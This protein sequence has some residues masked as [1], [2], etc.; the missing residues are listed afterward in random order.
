MPVSVADL[1]IALPAADVRVANGSTPAE[2]P[3]QVETGDFHRELGRVFQVRRAD[4]EGALQLPIVKSEPSP[5]DVLPLAVPQSLVE[6]QPVPA[7]HLLAG[8]STGLV[9]QLPPSIVTLSANVPTLVEA[10][11]FESTGP[12]RLELPV[13]S[14]EPIAERQYEVTQTVPATENDVE[15]ASNDLLIARVHFGR[16]FEF[17]QLESDRGRPEL[18]GV[19]RSGLGRT[20]LESLPTATPIATVDGLVHGF[21]IEAANRSEHLLRFG[22]SHRD[23]AVD[24]EQSLFQEI[25]IGAVSAYGSEQIHAVGV[26]EPE[27]TADRSDVQIILPFGPQAARQPIEARE[28]T[29]GRPVLDD[30]L[31][32]TTEAVQLEADSG[33]HVPQELST[34]ASLNDQVQDG[35]QPATSASAPKVAEGGRVPA[36]EALGDAAQPNQPV[37]D[38]ATAQHPIVSQSNISAAADR[39]EPGPFAVNDVLAS[40]VDEVAETTITLPDGTEIPAQVDLQV[41]PT[42]RRATQTAIE[43]PVSDPAVSRPG[44]P[45]PVVRQIASASSVDSTALD[46]ETVP[47]PF[48]PAVLVQPAVGVNRSGRPAAVERPATTDARVTVAPPAATTSSSTPTS[49][50]SVAPVRFDQPT[51]ALVENASAGVGRDSIPESTDVPATFQTDAVQS[52]S[53]VAEGGQVLRREFRPTV[54]TESPILDGITAG[55]T[56]AV[57]EA[58][59]SSAID[60]PEL[61]PFTGQVASAVTRS[62]QAEALPVD[63]VRE[64]TIR[65]DPPELGALLIRMRTTD[66][67]MEVDV[68]AAD[69]VT[70]EMLSRRVPEIEQLLRM[71]K[72]GV[73]VLTVNRLPSDSGDASMMSGRNDQSSDHGLQGERNSGHDSDS[74]REHPRQQ[75]NHIHRGAQVPTA[76]RSQGGIRA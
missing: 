36:V 68:E 72:T 14:F 67:G 32:D 1:L 17:T 37:E 27:R 41:R 48:R 19:G 64:L 66:N 31:T 55:I 34:D 46:A 76:R 60:A 56:P 23:D 10:F 28:E 24:L 61:L 26:E 71:Q 8:H 12:L 11:N 57:V 4:H 25:P 33:E 22:A 15:R 35:D 20:V 69:E 21:G 65:L 52:A 42:K 18:A 5:Q 29:P 73:H 40:P 44:N 70:L 54:A 75:Q 43:R 2:G 16:S 39:V 7:P 45:G 49:T 50:E 38:S 53:F 51:A 9:T 59:G 58:N 13:T 3:S 6:S 30:D 62:L 74:R 47:N 63:T